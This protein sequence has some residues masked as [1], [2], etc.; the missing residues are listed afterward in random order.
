MKPLLLFLV[1]LTTACGYGL[2]GR[3]VSLPDTIKTIAVTNLTNRTSTPELDRYMTEAI[4]TELSGK[5]RWRVVPDASGL[6][7][8]AALTGSVNAVQMLPKAQNQGQATRVDL[9]VI[10]AL[11]LRDVKNNKVLW[12]NPSL[13]TVDEFPISVGTSLDPS[14]YLRQNQDAYRRIASKFGRTAVSAMLEG[15]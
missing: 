12:S 4:R 1:A 9:S 3:T 14:A 8:D 2:A 6:D 10:A 15:M 13:V 11:E 5:G 7:V